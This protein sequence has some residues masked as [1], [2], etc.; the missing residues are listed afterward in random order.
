MDN[1]SEGSQNTHS[2]Q[3]V[4][5]SLAAEWSLLLHSFAEAD[6]D[7]KE[8]LLNNIKTI[9]LDANSLKNIKKSLSDQ[10]R[11]MNQR[12][13]SIKTH[14]DELHAVIENLELVKSD[15]EDI[16]KQIHQLIAEGEQITE[17]VV[18]IEKELKRIREVEGFI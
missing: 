16:Q 12:M 15:P 7:Q 2:G 4:S 13:E 5:S 3:P 9:G 11:Q 10:R 1:D 18:L 17:Q 6:S 14:I 8:K